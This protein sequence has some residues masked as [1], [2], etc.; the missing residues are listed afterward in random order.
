VARR[1]ARSSAAVGISGGV[2]S[3]EEEDGG[4]VDNDGVSVEVGVGVVV[5]S[6]VV[7]GWT[8]ARRK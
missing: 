7:V 1:E 5:S 8:E 4:L 2:S 3:I 6:L